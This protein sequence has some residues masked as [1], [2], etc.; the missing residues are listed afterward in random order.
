MMSSA[1]WGMSCLVVLLRYAWS[2]A[3]HLLSELP[4]TTAALA[5]HCSRLS[6]HFAGHDCVACPHVL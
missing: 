6:T 5:L 2:A 1:V 3:W 4:G